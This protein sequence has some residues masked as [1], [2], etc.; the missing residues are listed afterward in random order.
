MSREYQG[1]A[2]AALRAQFFE[3]VEH[4]VQTGQIVP[5]I[6]AECLA[7]CRGD[8]GDE[9]VTFQT[10]TANRFELQET[11]KDV[12]SSA[13]RGLARFVVWGMILGG[14]CGTAICFLLA[15]GVMS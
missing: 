5:G 7:A 12:G 8:G 11:V 6:Y 3:Q 10:N 2:E 13:I 9:E 15:T 4:E 14:A 1:L